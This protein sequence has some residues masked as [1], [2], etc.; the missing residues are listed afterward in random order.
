MKTKIYITPD[1]KILTEN[2]AY[3]FPYQALRLQIL[4]DIKSKSE[5]KAKSSIK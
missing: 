1:L 3:E 5:S 2:L 4:K